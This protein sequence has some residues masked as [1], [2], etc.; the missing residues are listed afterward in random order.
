MSKYLGYRFIVK[1]GS[2]T[3]YVARPKQMWMEVSWPT[4]GECLYD[5]QLLTICVSSDSKV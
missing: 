5:R 3:K 1:L 4:S 2:S